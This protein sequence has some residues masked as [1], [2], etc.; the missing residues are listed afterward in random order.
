M[1]VTTWTDAQDTQLLDGLKADRTY[2]QIATDLGVSKA[3]VSGRIYRLRHLRPDDVPYKKVQTKLA[4]KKTPKAGSLTRFMASQNNK[5]K[6]IEGRL[7]QGIMVAHNP[8][9][10]PK[11][12]K[13]SFYL[14]VRSVFI[15]QITS[16]SSLW[17]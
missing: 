3:M 7:S 1:G 4:S 14:N 10:I 15:N 2:T 5:C 13:T 6:L 11:K 12:T 17:L 8:K 9:S 16:P